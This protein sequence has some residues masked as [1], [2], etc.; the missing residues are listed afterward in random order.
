M[1]QIRGHEPYRVAAVAGGGPLGTRQRVVV[2]EV[3]EGQ[4]VEHRGADA[5]S[6]EHLGPLRQRTEEG[7]PRYGFRAGGV[8][9]EEDLGEAGAQQILVKARGAGGEL[10]EEGRHLDVG[11]SHGEKTIGSE[12][13]LY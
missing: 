3:V 12:R 1:Q 7:L 9:Y 2:V 10:C 13:A 5:G 6:R 8:A 4:L 11:G